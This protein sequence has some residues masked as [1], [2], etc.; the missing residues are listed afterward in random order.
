M[1]IFAVKESPASDSKKLT[2]DK[3]RDKITAFKAKMQNSLS[4]LES[5]QKR[6]ESSLSDS[7]S[8]SDNLSQ[9]SLDGP[10]EKKQEKVGTFDSRNLI[11]VV[12][13]N[14]GETTP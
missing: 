5:P 9:H 4:L 8:V 10:A 3:L 6:T 13:V 2:E 7:V 11:G 1:D 14:S 12:E